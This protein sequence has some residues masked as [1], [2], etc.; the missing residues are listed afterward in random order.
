M[1]VPVVTL[2]GDRHAGRVGASLLTQ[3][4]LPDLIAGTLAEYVEIAAALAH[5]P[6]RLG[7][8]RSSLRSRVAASPLCDAPA[9]ARNIESAY[10]AMWRRW[11][12]NNS[13]TQDRT[14][15]LSPD[16]SV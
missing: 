14:S 12:A 3:V 16:G 2:R 11:V 15:A 5:N 9:F 4:Q 13:E 10:R 8:L 1:G 6:A 7:D